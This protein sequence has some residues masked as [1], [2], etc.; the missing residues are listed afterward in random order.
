MAIS[1]ITIA[2][3]T[4]ESCGT[5]PVDEEWWSDRWQDIVEIRQFPMI[6]RRHVE[7]VLYGD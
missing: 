2:H 4:G 7:S 3:Y 1:C 6:R 5:R